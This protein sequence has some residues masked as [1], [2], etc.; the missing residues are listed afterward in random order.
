MDYFRSVFMYIDDGDDAELFVSNFGHYS[1][2][3]DFSFLGGEVLNIV[4]YASDLIRFRGKIYHL[5]EVGIRNVS[6]SPSKMLYNPFNP[7]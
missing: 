3:I 7:H 6:L 5:F 4:I 2:T 1:L